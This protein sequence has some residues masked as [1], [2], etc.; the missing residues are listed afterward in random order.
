M[1]KRRH[2]PI[3]H[4]E[5]ATIA[6]HGAQKKVGSKQR[7][8]TVVQDWPKNLPRPKIEQM[9]QP[10]P[11]LR[12]SDRAAAAAD[13]GRLTALPDQRSVQSELP[14]APRRPLHERRFGRFA[15]PNHW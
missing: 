4:S 15:T 1:V 14:V 12:A 13:A 8:Q 5:I 6:D 2:K 9:P 10:V 7:L 11:D 3:S